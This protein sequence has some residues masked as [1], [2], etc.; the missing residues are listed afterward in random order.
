MSDFE[1]LH[2]AMDDV[3]QPEGGGESQKGNGKNP[4]L[5][6]V[7]VKIDWEEGDLSELV[8][9]FRAMGFRVENKYDDFYE[10]STITITKE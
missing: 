8:D 10:V 7:T 3:F 6:P 4:N 9:V 2:E 1:K 5:G